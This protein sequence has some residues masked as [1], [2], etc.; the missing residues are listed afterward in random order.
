MVQNLQIVALL[1][2]Q[3][4]KLDAKFVATEMRRVKKDGQLRFS[5][6]EWLEELG[7]AIS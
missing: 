2:E 1:N 6:E 5:T 3:P 4:R 7:I